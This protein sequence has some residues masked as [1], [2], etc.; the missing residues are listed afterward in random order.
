M[1][2]VV[3]CMSCNWLLKYYSHVQK[4]FSRNWNN[5]SKY[6]VT[7]FVVTK[8]FHHCVFYTEGLSIHPSIHTKTHRWK[9]PN[10]LFFMHNVQYKQYMCLSLCTLCVCVIQDTLDWCPV[11]CIHSLTLVRL[12]FCIC[13][14]RHRIAK[15]VCDLLVEP[16][17]PAGLVEHLLAHQTKIWPQETFRYI[18]WWIVA[19]LSWVAWDA[20]SNKFFPWPPFIISLPYDHLHPSNSRQFVYKNCGC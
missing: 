2:V 14:F 5:E 9:T 16:R 6:L 3:K 1:S 17:L 11:D 13:A 18:V 12:Y 4:L 10:C 7:C 19:R 8:N 15:L 20:W